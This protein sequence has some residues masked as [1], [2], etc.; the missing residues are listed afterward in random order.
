MA[1]WRNRC[2]L[3]RRAWI[4]AGISA[5]ARAVPVALLLTAASAG[6]LAD[7]TLQPPETDEARPR[8]ALLCQ[9]AGE[10]YLRMRLQGA[11]EAEL[12]WSA[13]HQQCLGGPRPGGDGVRLLYKGAT[14]DGEPLLV[15]IGAGPLEPGQSARHVGANITI[16]REG[17]GPF[18]STLGDD[19]CAL[20]AVHQEPVP[21]RAKR[22]RLSARGYCTQPAR[23]I[24]GDSAV[25]VSRFDVLALVDY[26]SPEL[27]AEGRSE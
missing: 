17:G 14:A 11:I 25:L 23:S 15:V 4:E 10:G 3:D 5:P 19:K 2:S 27:P 8:E 7:G 1:N 24:N 9:P 12:D 26:G 6:V 16:V 18:F 21:P 13:E 22:F 20:D